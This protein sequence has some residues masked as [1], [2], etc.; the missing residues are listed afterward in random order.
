MSGHL[1]AAKIQGFY[2]DKLQYDFNDDTTGATT[3]I[4]LSF[5]ERV[6]LILALRYK[7]L[8]AGAAPSGGGGTPDIPFEIVGHLTQIDTGVINAN[9]MNSRFEKFLKS[10]ES[11]ELSPAERQATLDELHKSFASLTQEEQKYANIFLHDVQNGDAALEVG[12]TFRDYITL[13]QSNAKNDQ[14]KRVST[15][16][17]L[18]EAMLRNMMNLG[19]TEANLNE[20]AR[21]DNLK[22]T[23]DKQK[24]KEYFENIEGVTISL[25]NVNM[26]VHKLLA[27]FVLRGGEEV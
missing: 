23:V 18:D 5:D 11:G 26:K 25:K 13:Y 24:A 9:Y 8:F 22:N 16:F 3:V 7:E 19:L 12:K 10:L 14:I 17:G 20:F 2:W 6:Y 15:V 21:F 1:E 27:R 4:E